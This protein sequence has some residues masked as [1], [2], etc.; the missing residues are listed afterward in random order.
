M[1]MHAVTLPPIRDWPQL[2]RV[3]ESMAPDGLAVHATPTAWLR[4]LGAATG[5][6]APVLMR[7]LAIYRAL[8]ELAALARISREQLELLPFAGVEELHNLVRFVRDGRVPVDELITW[9][10]ALCS[11]DLNRTL[12]VLRRR[13][14]DL[15]G[16]IGTDART[17]VQ[18]FASE[19]IAEPTLLYD[20]THLSQY[21]GRSITVE[22]PFAPR[23]SLL[24]P[25]LVAKIEGAGS[26]EVEL[27][28]GVGSGF[29]R[30]GLIDRCVRM[31]QAKRVGLIDDWLFALTYDPRT[32]DVMGMKVVYEGLRWLQVEPQV[33]L[34]GRER[35]PG[36]VPVEGN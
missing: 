13:N 4:H 15:R 11:P 24:V 7:L 6:N 5:R 20:A 18:Q 29:S 36:L 32:E 2:A 31:E 14:R 30:R 21:H 23:T 12:P 28:V 35:L 8:D 9:A 33:L 10:T 16:A 19:L 22:A 17:V 34:I 1:P 25:D 26:V 3:L 27:A